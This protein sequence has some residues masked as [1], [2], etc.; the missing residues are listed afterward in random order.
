MGYHNL[1][2]RHWHAPPDFMYSLI[3]NSMT[4]NPRLESFRFNSSDIPF[5]DS[6]ILRIV[7]ALHTNAFASSSLIV[8]ASGIRFITCKREE[9]A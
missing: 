6:T 7:M 4:P 8:I 2:T 5:G 9:V 3:L 1:S